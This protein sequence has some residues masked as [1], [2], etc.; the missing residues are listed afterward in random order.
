MRLAFFGWVDED[1]GSVA[2]GNHVLLETLLQMGHE[3]DLFGEDG[4]VDPSPRLQEQPGYTHRLLRQRAVTKLVRSG[5]APRSV[6]MKILNVLTLPLFTRRLRNL[7]ELCHREKPYDVM[8]FL[9]LRATCRPAALPLVA[10]IQGVEVEEARALR[11]RRR[12]IIELASVPRYM[13]YSSYYTFDRLLGKAMTV[14]ADLTLCGSR[15]SLASLV[16]S[17]HDPA[18]V[19][20]VPYPIDVLRF[21]PNEEASGGK[22]ASS[23]APEILHF[24]RCDPRKRVDLLLAAFQLVQC[25]YPGS[26][27]TIVGRPGLLPGIVKIIRGPG[28]TYTPHVDRHEIPKLLAHADLVVQT[29]ESENFGSAVAEALA[30]G[31]P[32]VVGP[33]NG[34]AD[35]I[36]PKSIVFSAY[37][38]RAICD[39]ILAV[40]DGSSNSVEARV[41]RRE[42]VVDELSPNAVTHRFLRL[43]EAL[44]STAHQRTGNG[45][46]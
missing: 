8:V 23:V 32:V 27:L 21:A 44:V 3:V 34:T 11:R 16:S 5:R 25:H 18:K 28:V 9:G 7:V 2:S 31:V 36:D 40:V 12:L 17:G 43:V 10:W 30:C 35:Y 14:E 26:R 38:P 15:W 45:K 6:S 1:A 41:R 20:I 37:T 22:S 46:Q 13:L 24:G 42:K 19:A 4:F 39:A 33:T 29:S